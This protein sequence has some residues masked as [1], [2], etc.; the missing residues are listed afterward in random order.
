MMERFD[1]D[2]DGQVTKAEADEHRQMQFARF[3]VDDDGEVTAEE[4]QS[5]MNKFGRMHRGW[6]RGFNR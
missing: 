2:N 1:A 6:G 5:G 3:D 4:L